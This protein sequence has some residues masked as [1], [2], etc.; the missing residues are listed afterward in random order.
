MTLLPLD[1][2]LHLSKKT[3]LWRC[4]GPGPAGPLGDEGQGGTHLPSWALLPGSAPVTPGHSEEW[5]VVAAG[6]RQVPTGE[7]APLYWVQLKIAGGFGQD[8]DSR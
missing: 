1:S 6:E 7:E 2:T 5:A 4:E 3:P 8:R